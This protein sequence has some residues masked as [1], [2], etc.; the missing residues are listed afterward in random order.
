MVSSGTES[1]T[2]VLVPSHEGEIFST[3]CTPALS[4]TTTPVPLAPGSAQAN[5]AAAV[6]SAAEQLMPMTD[7]EKNMRREPELQ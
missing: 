5:S 2:Q 6:Q 7:L 1:I 4:R 3:I